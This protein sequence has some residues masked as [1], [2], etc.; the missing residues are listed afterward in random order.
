MINRD[1][2]IIELLKN[3]GR[4]SVTNISRDL[5]VPDT[6]IHYR[7]KKLKRFIEK[8]TVSL[9]YEAMGY[10]LYFVELLPEKY[11][12]DFITEKNIETVCNNLKKRKDVV[13]VGQSDTSIFAF[14]KSKEKLELDIPGAKVTKNFEIRRRAGNFVEP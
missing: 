6:T 12:L 4:M 5:N 1:L 8:F 14:V 3:N 9:N 10:R 11:S 2:E 7:L 13:F